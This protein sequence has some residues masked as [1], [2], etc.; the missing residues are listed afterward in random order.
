MT[1]A[2][3]DRGARRAVRT[4]CLLAGG[5]MLT[6]GIWAL[7]WPASFADMIDFPPYNEHLLHDLGAFQIGIGL[8][9]CLAPVWSDATAVALVGFL[10]AGTLHALNHGRDHHLG[11]HQADTWGL[12]ALAGLAAIVLLLHLRQHRAHQRTRQR[13]TE[14]DR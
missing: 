13:Q 12:G 2:V 4:V 7:I 8:T 5:W 14:E 3:A 10:V 11:G 1:A 9:L 6:F